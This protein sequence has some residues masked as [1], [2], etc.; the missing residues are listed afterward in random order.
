MEPDSKQGESTTAAKA[1]Q[2]NLDASRYG[3]FA[4][5]GAGQEVARWFFYVG[6]AAGTV[7]KT[8]SAYDMSVSDAIYG[9]SLRYVSR[10]RLEAMLDHE[11]TLLLE[12]LGKNRG[13]TTRFF[14]FA[15]TVTT[16]SYSHRD[17]GHGWMGIRFQTE[18]C[19]PPSD[20]LIHTRLWDAENARQQDAL[21]ILGVNL[22]HAAFYRSADP[23]DVI[24]ALME[25][26]TRDRVEVDVIQLKG[27]AFAGVDGRLMSL[28]LVHQRLTNAAFFTATGEVVEPADLL[29]HKPVLIE[30]GSFRPVT[31]VTLDMQERSLAKMRRD[32]QAGG[33]EPVVLME[34]TLRNLQGSQP[35]IDHS[36]FLARADTLGVLGKTVMISNYSR[37]HNV[38]TYL[39]RYTQGRIV[40]VMG[41]PTL[42]ALFD[43]KHYADMEGG[44]LEAFGRLFKG[45]TRLDVYPWRRAAGG[46]LVTTETFKAP[47]RLEH[48]YAYLRGNGYIEPLEGGTLEGEAALPRNVLALLQKG[49][50]EWEVLVP[51]PVVACIKRRGLFGWKG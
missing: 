5:I 39:R 50:A 2:I 32:P 14:V 36:D 4:E 43:D 27:P 6:G 10:Q 49:G 22:I 44:I 7:A 3:T 15:D 23:N 13:A 11:W 34:M 19:A 8:M 48:L 47:D 1:L 16:H 24:A 12:R 40:M 46:E 31:H 21:G 35:D 9:P 42:A 18:A 17:D 51:A 33:H 26:L 29:H 28:Q 25:Q 45:P 20:I 30:R 38:A 41:I 37:F